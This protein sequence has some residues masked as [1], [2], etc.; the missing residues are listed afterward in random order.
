MKLHKATDVEYKIT[1]HAE[2]GKLATQVHDLA[3]LAFG[4][5]PGVLQP[6]PAHRAWYV[7]RPGMEAGLSMAALHHD[8]LVSSLFVTMVQMRLAGRLRSVGIVDTVMT[9]PEHRRRG[10]ARRLLAEAIQGMRALGLEASLLYTAADSMPCRFYQTLGYRPHA[11]VYYFR[12]L[13]AAASRTALTPRRARP[14]DREKLVEF[15]NGY[16]ASHDGYV[17]LDDALW[18]WRNLDRP[19]ELPANTY[20]VQQSG[21]IQGCLTICR[22][23]VV[24]SAHNSPSYILSNLAIAS[25]ADAA[26]IL[27]SLLSPVAALG[28][29][30]ILSVVADDD[31]NRLLVAFGFAESATEVGMVLQLDPQLKN[32]LAAPPKRWYVLTESVIGL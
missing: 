1:S 18:R 21:R 9:H 25:Q 6:S 7:R 24:A 11:L 30:L 16:F 29:M 4:S 5:Y 23:P 12:C 15:L 13:R 20:F 17:P 2:I 10:L 26:R 3:R 27:T 19:R 22:A 14:S 28:E 31:T 8:R 32:A